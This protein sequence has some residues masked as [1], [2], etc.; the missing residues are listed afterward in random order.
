MS[1]R[2]TSFCRHGDWRPLSSIAQHGSAAGDTEACQARAT[3]P[4]A[5]SVCP[6]QNLYPSMILSH[7]QMCAYKSAWGWRN[8]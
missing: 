6:Q 3:M 1:P 5:G 2:L 7:R 8:L 4:E